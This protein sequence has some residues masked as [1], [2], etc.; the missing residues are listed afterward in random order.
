MVV[1]C[2][3]LDKSRHEKSDTISTIQHL[4]NRVHKLEKDFVESNTGTSAGAPLRL[5]L[6][7]CVCMDRLNRPSNC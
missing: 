3:V 4:E 6:K 1:K 5:W 2:Q 7:N